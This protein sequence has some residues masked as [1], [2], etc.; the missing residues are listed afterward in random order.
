MAAALGSRGSGDEVPEAW[1]GLAQ[2]LLASGPDLVVITLGAGG[3]LAFRA[4]HTALVQ[5]AFPVTAIDTLGAGDAFTAGLAV[6]LAE[7]RPL[8][9][10]LRLG[11]ACGACVVRRK[12]A[13]E[14]LPDRAA[15]AALL[16]G[17]A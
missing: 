4:G 3:A 2:A 14:V 15:I 13:F 5:P 16:A 9:E 6:G 1:A 12:G 17:T 10:S 11:A 8:P 7:G